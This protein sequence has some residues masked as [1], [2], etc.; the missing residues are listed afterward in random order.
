ME[1]FTCAAPGIERFSLE[2]LKEDMP[3]M[4]GAGCVE[5][6]VAGENFFYFVI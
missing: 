1:R 5:F 3:Y 2:L 6:V 4:W